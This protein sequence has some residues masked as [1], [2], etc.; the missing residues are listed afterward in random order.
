[1]NA[2]CILEAKASC[3]TL[4]CKLGCL[5]RSSGYSTCSFALDYK[6]GETDV[7]IVGSAINGLAS[8]RCSLDDIRRLRDFCYS[9]LGEESKS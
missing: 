1:M 8:G 3:V 9:V 7:L 6:D 4:N 5:E 2:V